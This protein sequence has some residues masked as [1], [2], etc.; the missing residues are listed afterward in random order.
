MSDAPTPHS[1]LDAAAAAPRAD[2][3]VV[4]VT[5]LVEVTARPEAEAAAL[6]E[7]LAA[8]R[9]WAEEPGCLN[10]TVLRDPAD[11]V[12][13]LVSE[14]FASADDLQAHQALPATHEFVHRIQPHLAVP[15]KRTTW[16]VVAPP[17]G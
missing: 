1:P 3:P 14:T 5:V 15:P 7:L 6:G 12:R 9:R 13:F 16:H 4:P 2:A 17:R 10:I 11:A 8:T